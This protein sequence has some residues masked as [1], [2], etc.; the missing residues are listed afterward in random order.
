MQD[1]WIQLEVLLLKVSKVKTRETAAATEHY[2]AT[3]QSEFQPKIYPEL[4]CVCDNK[5]E[6]ARFLG[7]ITDDHAASMWRQNAE[8]S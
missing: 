2:L 6:I 1:L 3:L 5:Y 8:P 4:S 7:I